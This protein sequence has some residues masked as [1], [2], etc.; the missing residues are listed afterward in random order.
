MNTNKKY[1]TALSKAIA[2]SV[3]N[4]C[5]DPI[6]KNKK[7]SNTIKSTYFNK[8]MQDMKRHVMF[9]LNFPSLVYH[10]KY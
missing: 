4:T 9:H 6:R 7:A 2:F 8:N 5:I 3:I 1:L 10:K